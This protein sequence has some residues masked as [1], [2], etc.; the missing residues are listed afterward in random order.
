M[1][2]DNQQE[3]KFTFS[4]LMLDYRKYIVGPPNDLEENNGFLICCRGHK[5]CNESGKSTL[6]FLLTRH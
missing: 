6:D 4:S 3:V 1:R 2:S 5:N